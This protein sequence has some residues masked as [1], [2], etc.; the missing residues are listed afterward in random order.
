MTLEHL[1]TSYA[2]ALK[3]RSKSSSCK[4]SLSVQL[5]FQDFTRFIRTIHTQY[6]RVIAFAFDLN[7]SAFDLAS[8]Q[9]LRSLRLSSHIQSL[10]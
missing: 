2:A 9:D 1:K 6:K 5:F 4:Q 10:C 8:T 7:L 3:S